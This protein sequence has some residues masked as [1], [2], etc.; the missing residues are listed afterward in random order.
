MHRL[1]FLHYRKVHKS[2]VE[3]RRLRELEAR[4]IKKLLCWTV[5]RFAWLL[6]SLSQALI[7]L[8]PLSKQ[9]RCLIL[10]Q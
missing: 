9:Y 7:S 8:P 3:R 5:K 4:L 1:F 10:T 2:L 6:S